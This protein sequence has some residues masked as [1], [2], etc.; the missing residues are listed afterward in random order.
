MSISNNNHLNKLLV[1]KNKHQ[2]FLLVALF[3]TL[4]LDS[5]SYIMP[6]LGILQNLV[7][8]MALAFLFLYYLRKRSISRIVFI[9]ILYSFYLLVDGVFHGSGIQSTLIMTQLRIITM[10]MVLGYG[11]ENKVID[12]LKMF[13]VVSSFYVYLNLLTVIVFPN[14]LYTTDVYEGNWLLG[15]KNSAI[16]TM[17]PAICISA[18]Y[19]KFVYKKYTKHVLILFVASLITQIIT[20]CKT[21]I[22]GLVFLGILL[23]IIRKNELPEFVNIRNEVLLILAMILSIVSTSIIDNLNEFMVLLGEEKSL[24]SR[25]DVW[26]RAIE[27]FFKSPILGYGLQSTEGYRKIIDLDLGFTMFSH[28]HNFILYLLLQGGLI[29]VCLI[30]YLFYLLGKKCKKHNKSYMARMLIVMYMIFFILGIT[31]SMTG[32][33]LFLPLFV[34]AN[35]IK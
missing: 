31:E 25:F 2:L 29:G 18:A 20:D 16:Y 4:R 23:L 5:I 22:V 3:A 11:I 17:L 26:N 7:M 12:C 19:S 21:G 8:L 15:Y 14:G 35:S 24:S 27:L 32:A 30:I 10:A 33:I 34:F 13:T 28:P 6:S 9:I 1:V